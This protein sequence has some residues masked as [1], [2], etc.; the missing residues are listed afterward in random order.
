MV[1][2]LVMTVL[3]VLA[4]DIGDATIYVP[5]VG[6]AIVLNDSSATFPVKLVAPSSSTIFT[7]LFGS[8]P[9]SPDVL[10]VAVVAHSSTVPLCLTTPVRLR[11]PEGDRAAAAVHTCCSK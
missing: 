5:Y 11:R 8:A 3:A 6:P 2:I 1:I 7:T 4:R 9:L 10:V